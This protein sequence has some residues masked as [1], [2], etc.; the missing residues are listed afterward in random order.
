[1]FHDFSV[2]EGFEMCSSC[3]EAIGLKIP[4]ILWRRLM[5]KEFL[6]LLSTELSSTDNEE[7]SSTRSTLSLIESNAVRYT[8]GFIIKKLEQKFSKQKTKQ[9]IECTAALEE[10]AVKVRIRESENQP[11]HPS[12]KWINLVD[13]GG[14]CHV[15]DIVYD[16][17]IVI[18]HFVDK[19]LSQILKNGGKGIECIRKHNLS[20]ILEEEKVQ[21]MWSQVSLSSMDETVHQGLL[22]EIVH[23]WITTRGHSKT[24]QLKEQYKVQQKQGVKRKRSLQKELA[25]E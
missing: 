18:E 2:S 12:C 10:M 11:Q 3:E 21:S 15:Q 17:F 13:R 7:S 19:K 8:A 4:E 22:T 6:Q 20:W 14:L 5:E 1:M 25:S 9:A 16:L 24:H 23:L